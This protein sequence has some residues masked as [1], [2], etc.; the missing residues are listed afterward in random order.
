MEVEQEEAMKRL[1]EEVGEETWNEFVRVA[2]A[3]E[4]R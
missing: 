4:C 1:K 2:M 3:E